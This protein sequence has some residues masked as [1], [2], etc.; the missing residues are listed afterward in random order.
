MITENNIQK[1]IAENIIKKGNLTVIQIAHRLST[2]KDS[3]VIFMLNKGEIVERGKYDELMAL[4]GDFYDLVQ[5]QSQEAVVK[6]RKKNMDKEI[7][8]LEKKLSMKKFNTMVRTY[9]KK[10]KKLTSSLTTKKTGF[11]KLKM[12]HLSS[13]AGKWKKLR[14]EIKTGKKFS[15]LL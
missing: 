15:E 14:K 3:D 7:E 8:N 9:S 1:S 5:I 4:K 12:K 10:S 2:I 13:M 6:K 11:G